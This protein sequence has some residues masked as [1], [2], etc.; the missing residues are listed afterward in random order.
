MTSL[1]YFKEKCSICF[2]SRCEF[3]FPGCEDQFC[4]ECAKRFVCLFFP[5]LLLHSIQLAFSEA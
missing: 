5:P 4:F 1:D 3:Y 2:D